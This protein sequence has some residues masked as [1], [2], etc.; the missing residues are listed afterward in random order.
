MRIGRLM[1]HC[2][3]LLGCLKTIYDLHERPLICGL[4]LFARPEARVPLVS[5]S[6]TLES[7][8]TSK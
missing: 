6:L 8:K 7:A 5:E 3:Y 4:L 1:Y 2:D